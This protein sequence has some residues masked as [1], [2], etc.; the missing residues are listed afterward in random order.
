MTDQNPKRNSNCPPDDRSDHQASIWIKR[1]HYRVLD[2]LGFRHRPRF[3]VHDS[4]SKCRRLILRLPN[5]A[6]TTQ[7]LQVLRRL[8]QSS[9]L[10]QI[11]DT[12]IQG[13]DHL[14]VLSWTNGVDLGD[15]FQRVKR[16]A[17]VTPSAYESLRLVRGLT[18]GLFQLHQH[19][20]LIHGDL[21]PENLILTR[22]PSFLAMIDFGSAWQVERSVSRQQGD[23][24]SLVYAAPELLSQNSLCDGRSDQFAA[25]VI[26]YQLLTGVVPYNSLG[27]QAG[28]DQYRAHFENKPTPPSQTSQAMQTLPKSL[29]HELD[30]VVLTGTRL[31]PDSRFQTT[32]AWLDAIE[33]LFLKFKLSQVKTPLS[34]W[35][36]FIDRLANIVAPKC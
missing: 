10:P 21:K 25:S 6:A 7:H 32:S 1:R 15:Y 34:S 35:Q 8:S 31:D 12:Q 16:G 30:Y 14:V 23:G 3:L 17:V 11:I 22:K 18:H 27:G 24:T 4:A 33:T 28:L 29:A 26:L 13:D 20:Q 9:S 36:R 5:D 19:A 2:E